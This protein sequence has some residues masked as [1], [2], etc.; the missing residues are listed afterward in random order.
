MLTLHWSG[1]AWMRSPRWPGLGTGSMGRQVL[2][3]TET[4]AW[5]RRDA[6]ARPRPRI[7][8]RRRLRCG[9]NDNKQDAPAA[10]AGVCCAHQATYKLR[11]LQFR[12]LN[13]R[14][15]IYK[16]HPRAR[17]AQ[18]RHQRRPGR[19]RWPGI[20]EPKRRHQT[21]DLPARDL[22]RLEPPLAEL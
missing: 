20:D 1:C 12:R 10:A 8:R 17:G 11:R 9:R 18:A 4:R 21:A 22:L 14:G 15:S 7:S 6:V 2:A 13:I 19:R 16:N 3:S 5:Q